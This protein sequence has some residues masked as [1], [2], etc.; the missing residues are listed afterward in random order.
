M[1]FIQDNRHQ[2]QLHCFIVFVFNNLGDVAQSICEEFRTWRIIP[3]TKSGEITSPGYPSG[4]VG[5]QTCSVQ[6]QLPRY[7][8]IG[9]YARDFTMPEGR[10]YDGTQLQVS[11]EGD[12]RIMHFCG[13]QN[14]LLYTHFTG[15]AEGFVD[16]S[17]KSI[18]QINQTTP[19][20]FHLDYK[21]M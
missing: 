5:P 14:A 17:F 13:N 1:Y 10:C 4:V 20:K 18:P 15:L 8:W 11:N 3:V 16:L 2:H 21:G 7:Y 9:V 6:L 19:T 12:Q